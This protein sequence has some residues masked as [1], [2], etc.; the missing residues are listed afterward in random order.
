M[1]TMRRPLDAFFYVI[2]VLFSL[3][4]AIVVALFVR[5]LVVFGGAASSL[6]FGFVVFTVTWFAVS[7]WMWILKW[8]K[9]GLDNSWR[10]LTG[11]RPKE[12]EELSTWRWG[13]QALYAWLCI[14]V[15]LVAA[16]SV[17]YWSKG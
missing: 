7:M 10:F 1:Q 5:N 2:L 4:I 8:K 11:P 17:L 9:L 6:M 14:L 13:R 3:I 15:A 12:G 16:A